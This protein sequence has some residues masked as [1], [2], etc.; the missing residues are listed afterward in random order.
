MPSK[1]A[2]KGPEYRIIGT[3]PLRTD[4]VDKVTGRA[5]YGADIRLPEALYGCLLRS[6]HA[7]ARIRAIDTGTARAL[8]GVKAVVTAADL[9]KA[10]ADNQSQRYQLDHLLTSGASSLTA[11]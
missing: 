11:S 10:G 3:R 5:L 9:P 2:S 6:P 4:G 7:H 8:L 1:T